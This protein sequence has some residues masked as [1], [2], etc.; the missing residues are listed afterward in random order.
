MSILRDIN[1]I[2]KEI[3]YLHNDGLIAIVSLADLL[4]IY[5][6]SMRYVAIKLGDR[7]FEEEGI[8]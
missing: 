6:F 8:C 1:N 3:T 2:R 7:P 5:G 4:H